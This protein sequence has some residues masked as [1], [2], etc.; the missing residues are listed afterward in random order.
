MSESK[1]DQ[2]KVDHLFLLI[3]ENPL[4]NYV[5]AN[6][7]LN[8]G[9]TPYLVYTTGTEISAKRLK[10]ILDSES[11]GFK[12][13]QF[14]PIGEY[15]SDAYHIREIIRSIIATLKTQSI[16]LNYTGGTKAMS[17]HSYRT[18]FYEELNNKTYI[19]REG[20]LFSYLDPRR[21]EMCIDRE[22][23]ERVRIPVTAKQ[24]SVELGKVFQIHG[25]TW[26]ETSRP[27]DI[28]QLPNAATAFANF[29]NDEKLIKIWRTWCNEVL[30]KHTKNSNNYW[31]PENQLTQKDELSN[32]PLQ[33][34][35]DNKVIEL[36]KYEAINEALISLG[37]TGESLSLSAIQ[38]QGL[39]SLEE[40]CKWL[41]G[42]WL[43]HYVL[44]QVLNIPKSIY[45][46]DAATSFWIKNPINSKNT[47]FQFDVAFMR[48]YQLFAISCTTIERKFDCK[49]KLFEAYIRAQQLGGIEARVAL[50]CCAS[51]DDVN[52]LET[53]IINVLNPT[54]DDINKNYKLAV[55]GREDLAE[56]ST[57]I[58]EWIRNNEAK[59]K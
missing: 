23:N 7:L 53:E 30:R 8:K 55:F 1:F 31:L 42:E 57:R 25:W 3:G 11:K 58:G 19:Q 34:Q 46:H 20:I 43:E 40:V 18:M 35:L 49:S 2:H 48:G 41:D 13:T 36:K 16:G 50:V 12:P 51:P 28:P 24:L 32:L 15:E 14:V 4:P 44:Q 21:L 9:G 29:H 33:A 56:L 52:A 45:I 38:K 5:A 26:R 6:L 54:P 47:K 22:G 17:V 39:K 37:I 59:Q 27:I 10:R